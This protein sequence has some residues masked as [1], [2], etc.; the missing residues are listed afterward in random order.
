MGLRGEVV[1]GHPDRHVAR[2]ELDA[3]S[4]RRVVYL[5]REHV[6]GLRVRLRNWLAGFGWASR[7]EREAATL[8]RLEAAGRP[9]PQWMAYGADGTGRAFLIVD[10]LAGMGDLRAVLGD[11]AL[12]PND[13][14]RLAERAGRAV[15]ELHAAGFGT[16]EL[17]AKHLFANPATGDMS[18]VDWQSAGK[19]GPVS[20]ADRARQLAGLDASLAANL[21]SP[22]NRLRF[23]RAYLRATHPAPRF[24]PFV[25]AITKQAVRLRG[26]SSARDQRLPPAPRLVWLAGEQVCVMPE[27]VD[28]WPDPAVCPPFYLADSSFLIPHSS[29]SDEEWVTFPD[30]RRGLLT[31]FTTL[32]PLGRFVAAIRERPWR[33]PAA[34]AARVLF[35]LRRHGIPAPNLLAF[36]QWMRSPVRA[37]SFLLCEPVA[38]AVPVAVRLAQLPGDRQSRRNLL[39]RCGETLR[40]LHEAGCRPVGARPI[41]VA[42][43]TGLVAVEGPSAVRLVKK[44]LSA[45]D[46]TADVRRFLRADLPGL[47][48]ADR[49]R[50]VRGYLGADWS[51]RSARRTL[52]ARTA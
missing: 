21:A 6:V 43:R 3:G 7:S 34:T 28:L 22:R 40:R 46:R 50:V 2:V 44:R 42:S 52:L 38:A 45:S 16:P 51:D 37:D 13:R 15:G 19:P 32:D 20:D 30:G 14:W 12:S 9:G 41:L 11:I 8:R 47:G 49:A 4:A 23:V 26:R 36:G 25:R 29:F 17:A 24:G 33:S 39:H 27:L 48:R 1:C 35:H 5:K 18:L 10:E 31:R